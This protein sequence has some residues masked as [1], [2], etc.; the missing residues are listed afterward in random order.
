MLLQIMLGL[1][2]VY[3]K[4]FVF[5]SQNH[6]VINFDEI[7][8]NTLDVMFSIFLTERSDHSNYIQQWDEKYP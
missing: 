4:A 7:V 5:Q 3:K 1:C 8:S 2:V 6:A